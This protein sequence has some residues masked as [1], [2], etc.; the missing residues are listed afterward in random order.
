MKVSAILSECKIKMSSPLVLTG[1]FLNRGSLVCESKSVNGFT[2][3]KFITW[4]V[5]GLKRKRDQKFQKLQN[6]DVVFLHE[7][8]IGVRDEHIIKRLKNEWYVSYTNYTS[9]KGTAVLVRKTLHFEYISDE[10]D[11]CGMYVLLKCKLE[12]QWLVFITMTQTQKPL[13]NFQVVTCYQWPQ[14]CWWSMEISRRFLIHLLT[15]TI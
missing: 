1:N 11:N 4:N 6:A 13:K 9:R 10:R 5:N 7:T 15:K 3:H 12:G 14:G 2:D 8:H